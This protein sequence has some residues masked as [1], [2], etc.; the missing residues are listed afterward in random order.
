MARRSGRGGSMEIVIRDDDSTR[1]FI[2]RDRITAATITDLETGLMD[3]Y[4]NDTRDAMV[5]IGA[6]TR[7]DSLTLAVF[8][9]IKNMLKEKGRK[10]RLINPSDSVRRIIEIASLEN[11]LLEN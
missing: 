4:H 9:K 3:F 5:D 1:T 7:I 8:L 6:V 11:F 10:F 2:I